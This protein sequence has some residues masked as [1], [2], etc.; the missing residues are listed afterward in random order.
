MLIVL[1]LDI[2]LFFFNIFIG[3]SEECWSIMV[4]FKT[5]A[6]H[7]DKGNDSPMYGKTDSDLKNCSMDIN[8][9]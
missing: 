9:I 5:Y 8:Q 4:K 7:Q 1:L 2:L 6:K 3:C